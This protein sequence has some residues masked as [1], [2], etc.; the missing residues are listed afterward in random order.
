MRLVLCFVLV[1]LAL[2]CYEANAK[3][4]EAVMRESTIFI[5]KSE[6]DLEEELKRYDAPP[7]A[8][9]AKLEVKKCIDKNLNFFHKI[10]VAAILS[11]SHG[12]K[13][14][15]GMGKNEKERKEGFSNAYGPK[16]DP[17]PQV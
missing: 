7:E 17:H 5:M 8:V 10:G 16:L 4:C 12:F 13:P 3:V 1:I 9:Q 11:S 2:C 15:Q 6:K 14:R